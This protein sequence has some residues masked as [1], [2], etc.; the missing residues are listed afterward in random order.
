MTTDQNLR[1]GVLALQ[2]HL[3]DDTQFASACTAWAAEPARPLPDLLVAR[4]WISEAGRREVDRL[5]DSGRGPHDPVPPRLLRATAASP[6]DSFVE[7]LPPQSAVAESV[8]PASMQHSETLLQPRSKAPAGQAAG[9][10]S[11]TAETIAPGLTKE[12]SHALPP[13]GS[14]GA[15]GWS[16]SG[17]TPSMPHAET[18]LPPKSLP[19]AGES[20]RP[21]SQHAETF[22]P[23]SPV[24]VTSTSGT[25]LTR[26]PHALQHR[27][28]ARRRGAR[29]GLPVPR[30]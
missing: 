19:P 28:L 8:S 15:A 25:F 16:P 2:L 26:A 23:V 30:Q 5:L 7:T 20:A 21:P 14:L 13:P 4:G 12:P 17:L 1:F 24:R 18:L 9:P 3:L 6:S 29:P 10:L 27:G 22:A 11:Q